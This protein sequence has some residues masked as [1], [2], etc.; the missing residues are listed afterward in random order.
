MTVLQKADRRGSSRAQID[1]RGVQD[2]VLLLTRD[3][4]R[5]MLHVSP[6]NFELKSED[7][8]DAIIDTY[9]SFLNSVGTRLQILVRTRELDMDQYL[10]DLASMEVGE[11]ETVYRTQLEHYGEFI[12]GL[13]SS[14][15]ILSRNFYVVVPYDA[16]PKT[17]FE[18]V[19]EQ[20]EQKADIV[21]KGLARLGISSRRLGDLELLD[22][23]YSFYSPAASKLQ[24]LSAQALQLLHT[25]YVG[26]G[27]SHD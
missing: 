24:P 9:E 22:L 6:I 19:R 21:E 13:I 1:I 15:K 3:R 4:Y 25:E 20:L 26:K 27:A 12:K 8:R 10:D 18:S 11:T 7:E 14:N 2:G 17:D 16:A 23:F 5:V